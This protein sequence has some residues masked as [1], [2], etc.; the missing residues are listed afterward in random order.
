LT[1]DAIHSILN[2]METSGIT[3][4]LKKVKAF[5]LGKEKR[6]RQKHRSEINGTVKKLRRLVPLWEQYD[7]KKVYLYGS[8][9]GGSIHSGSDIDIALDGDIDYT[10]LLALFREVDRHFSRDIDLR[11]LKELPFKEAVIEKGVVVYEK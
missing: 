1:G 2:S 7:I 4:D 9:A 10:G 11:F 3:I 8:F 5:L 6:L